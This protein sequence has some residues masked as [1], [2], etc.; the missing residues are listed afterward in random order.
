MIHHPEVTE[1]FVK[2]NEGDCEKQKFSRCL[3]EPGYKVVETMD[4]P[5]FIQTHLPLSL[6]PG[7]LNSGCK[8]RC[9]HIY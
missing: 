3:G 4:S 1:E 5:R 7:I 2:I 9:Y 8:V 6:M